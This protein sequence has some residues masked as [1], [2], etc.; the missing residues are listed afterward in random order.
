MTPIA[1]YMTGALQALTPM[2]AAL[3]ATGLRGVA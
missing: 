1:F 2:L 3:L